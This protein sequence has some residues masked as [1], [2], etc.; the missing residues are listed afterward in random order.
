MQPQLPDDLLTQLAND[1]IRLANVEKSLT[2][3]AIQVG[4]A[5]MW[6]GATTYLPFNYKFADGSAIDRIG[7][8]AV[9]QNFGTTFGVGDGSNTFNLP[10]Y[11]SFVLPVAPASPTWTALPYASGYSDFAGF[12]AGQY[13]KD[14]Q[15]FVHLRGLFKFTPTGSY[16]AGGTV[17]T[18]PAGFRPAATE[19][20]PAMGSI[21][22]GAYQIYR[23]AID[24]TGVI[25]WAIAQSNWTGDFF[26]LAGITFDSGVLPVTSTPIPIAIK[27]L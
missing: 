5:I 1:G 19:V 25:T 6:P 2:N 12:Q 15:G 3:D 18:L 20:F 4:T 21:S 8:A 26:S 24:S 10:N 23:V 14:T 7:F 13:S 11:T 16:S 22:S 9:F 27:V 17:A